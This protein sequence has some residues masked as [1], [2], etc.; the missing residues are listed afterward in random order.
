MKPY[1]P[2]L[3]ALIGAIVVWVTTALAWSQ[4]QGLQP[5]ALILG[6]LLPFVALAVF[7]RTHLQL[8][9]EEAADL[10]SRETRLEDFHAQVE[11]E[12]VLLEK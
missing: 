9:N 7:H 4:L 10:K 6:P 5:W 8:E 11:E 12:A 2:W 1:L 3:L